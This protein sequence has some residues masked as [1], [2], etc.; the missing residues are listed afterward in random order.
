MY[1]EIDS[2][3]NSEMI[4]FDMDTYGID[5][6]IL[7]PSIAGTTN[8]MQAAI[9][10]KYPDRFRAECS[11]QTL[12]LKCMR[13]EA[14]WSIE[15]ALEEVEA[16]LTWGKGK[17]VSIGENAPGG[18]GQVR[19]KAPTFEER[20]EEFMAIAAVAT[21]YDVCMDFH[22]YLY[23]GEWGGGPYEGFSIVYAVA[24]KYP[25]ARIVI[26]HGGGQ[27]QEDI[28]QACG[29]AARC[30]NV[31][32]ETGY[33]RAEHYELALKDPNVGAYKLIW[34]GGDTGSRIWS[35]YATTPGSKLRCPTGQWAQFK[36]PWPLPY[37][38]DWYGFPTHQIHRLKDMDLAIQDEINLVIGG[39]AA[40]IYKLPVPM[41]DMFACGRPE[42]SGVYWEETIPFLPEEQIQKKKKK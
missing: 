26:M 41:P 27:H 36:N 3:D 17:F 20:R 38:P 1:R 14:T 42:L 30:D 6:G 40:K 34:G 16:A 8:E 15:A 10:D 2:S 7:K 33:W 22:E 37:Q 18:M 35:H 29:L 13:G 19:P 32:L 11:D 21:K 4:L 39:N 9:V 24:K 12:R 25:E 31:Y 28:R 5:M 23:A